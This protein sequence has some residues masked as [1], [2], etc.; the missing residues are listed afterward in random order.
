MRVFQLLVIFWAG[1]V[2]AQ[3]I[4]IVDSLSNE[5]LAFATVAFGDGTGTFA[6]DE[7]RLRFSR[8]LYPKVDS[9]AVSSM[10]YRELKISVD[11][12]RDTIYLPPSQKQLDDVLL[13]AELN[14]KFKK[15]KIDAEYHDEYKNCWLPTVESEI[16]RRFV[17]EDGRPTQI[18]HVLLPILKEESQRSGKGKLRKF[19]TMFRLNFYDVI[20]DL[21]D[22]TSTYPSHTFIVTQESDDVVEVDITDR[23][24][25][26]PKGGLFVGVQVLGYADE[27][28]DLIPA[29]KYR[30]IK[31]RRGYR[32]VSTTYRP[33]LPFTDELD[34]TVTYVRRVFLNDKQWQIYDLTYNRNSALVRSGHDNYG[35][36]VEMRVYV[37]E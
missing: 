30:E 22:P 19:R 36:G 12:L 6:D 1:I 14:G 23:N 11:K 16:A 29:K 32:K 13:L 7:G 26:I 10:G 17:R 3:D 31:T 8:K 20:N 33:L 21:P 35:M 27:E 34:A 25:T 28:G 4:I 18:T 2:S 5:T 9:I 37:N 24:I 15:E